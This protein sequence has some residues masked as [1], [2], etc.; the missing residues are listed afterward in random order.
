MAQNFCLFTRV[1]P[2]FLDFWCDKSKRK[3]THFSD[4]LSYFFATPPPKKFFFLL[5]FSPHSMGFRREIF[6]S[7]FFGGGG[8]KFL[9]PPPPKKK[10]NITNWKE[11]YRFGK[12][13]NSHCSV[14]FLFPQKSVC[15]LNLW[16]MVLDIFFFFNLPHTRGIYLQ[17]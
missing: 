4:G 11:S 2:I 6:F 16:Q 15:P 17:I 10:K 1:Q 5:Q 12:M 7:I 3:Y 8:K 9:T 14:L 13:A